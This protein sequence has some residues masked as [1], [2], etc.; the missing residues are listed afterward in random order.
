MVGTDL[1]SRVTLSGLPA[2]LLVAAVAAWSGGTAGATGAAAGGVI[3]LANFR[4]MARGAATT[5]AAGRAP[6][7]AF[8]LAGLRY[9]GAFGAMAL[10]LSTGW[11]HPVALVAGLSVLPP[12]LILQGL[13]GATGQEG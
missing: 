7:L 5:L 10:V 12:V 2:I 9:L 4:W 1:V 3:A 8:A 6:R 11:A 13:R